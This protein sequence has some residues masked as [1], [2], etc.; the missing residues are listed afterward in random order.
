M[1]RT[2]AGAPAGLLVGLRTVVVALAVG[3]LLV[4]VSLVWRLAEGAGWQ[5]TSQQL[6]RALDVDEDLSVLNWLSAS[7]FLLTGLLLAQAARAAT[8]RDRVW[9]VVLAAGVLFVSLDEASGVHDPVQVH[10]ES[11]LAAGGLPALLVGAT[12]LVA[13]PVGLAVLRVLPRRLR[14]RAVLAVLI[15]AVAAVGVDSLGP[16]LAESP[17]RRL[18]TWYVLKSSVEELLEL[19]AA[20]LLLDTARRAAAGPRTAGEGNT[21]AP[22]HT[23]PKD[24]ASGREDPAREPVEQHQSQPR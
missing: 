10:A 13:V 18:E 14:W 20:C 19:F 16:D 24:A 22:L 2:G 5:P 17:E 6:D 8:G 12:A 21:R 9:W 7:V 4:A 15:V 1:P 11:A 23:A 3:V